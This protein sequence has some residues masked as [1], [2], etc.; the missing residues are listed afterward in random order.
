MFHASF[1]L[2]GTSKGYYRFTM[3]WLCCVSFRAVF[4]EKEKDLGIEDVLLYLTF[5]QVGFS[6]GHLV[7]G[8]RSVLDFIAM[9]C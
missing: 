1:C 3:V 6:I 9:S 8:A 5:F 7:R 4:P 2:G